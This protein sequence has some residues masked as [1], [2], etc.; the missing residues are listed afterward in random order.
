MNSQYAVNSGTRVPVSRHTHERGRVDVGTEAGPGA[1][2]AT[3]DFAAILNL[4]RQNIPII[5]GAAMLATVLAALALVYYIHPLYRAEAVLIVKRS[6]NLPTEGATAARTP[7]VT[8]PEF[9]SVVD[10]LTSTTVLEAAAAD[11]SLDRNPEFNPTIQGTAVEAVKGNGIFAKVQSTA[12]EALGRVREI[13]SPVA[14]E[15]PHLDTVASLERTLDVSVKA[16]S[17]SIS[18]KATARDPRMAAALANAVADAA[19]RQ[20]A[21]AKAEETKRIKTWLDDRLAELSARVVQSEEEIERLR[22]DTGR[23]QGQNATILSEQL[24]QLSKELLDARAQLAAAQAKHDEVGRL[25]SSPNGLATTNE[26]LMSPTINRLREQEAKIAADLA[27]AESHLGPLHPTCISLRSQL[28]DTRRNIG[29]ETNRIAREASG[30]VQLLEFQVF[31]IEHNKAKLEARI[32]G[33]KASEVQLKELQNDADS[34]RATLQAFAIFRAKVADLPS[35]EAPDLAIVSPAK[36]NPVPV[37]PNRKKILVV[38]ALGSLV[39]GCLV[40]MIR[41]SLDQ[42]LRS[43]DQVEATLG[44]LTVALVPI[45]RRRRDPAAAALAAPASI[46]CESVRHLYAAVDV[47]R[48]RRSQFRVLF[49]SALPREGKSVTALMLARQA[50]LVGVNTLLVRLDLRS[51]PR[52]D[53]QSGEYTIEITTDAQSGASIFTV[54]TRGQAEFKALHLKE[55]WDRLDEACVG[56]DLIVIDSAPVLSVSDTKIIARFA[57]MTILVVKWGSTKLAVAAEAVRQLR[58]A[59]AELDCAVLTQVNPRRHARYGYTGS[60]PYVGVH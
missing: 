9:A 35:I 6:S 4:L 32:E 5:C 52:L 20:D 49:T 16:G 18:L 45:A 36:P 23:L 37:W 10:V 8:D 44:L 38:V 11:L 57:D 3:I 28:A 56:R 59:G 25:G 13:L 27:A 12:A 43:A 33:Q 42:G 22:G 55:F 7:D 58:L 48:A 34:S 15:D 24:S 2:V 17:R 39:I 47:I 51:A 26:A 31:T 40:A 60:G 21:S 19:V 29:N 30:R 50:S 54:R 1:V 46:L 41:V 14:F 53:E